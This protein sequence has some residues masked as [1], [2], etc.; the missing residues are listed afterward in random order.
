MSEFVIALKISASVLALFVF[1][2]AMVSFV[3]WENPFRFI[4]PRFAVRFA[5]AT[6]VYVLVLYF[7][8]WGAK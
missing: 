2:G 3:M 1:A 5:V 7:L 6:I 8:P 4:K